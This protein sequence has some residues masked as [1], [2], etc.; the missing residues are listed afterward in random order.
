MAVVCAGFGADDV[1]G[2]L[3]QNAGPEGNRHNWP[4][5]L[6]KTSQHESYTEGRRGVCAAFA[7][8]RCPRRLCDF[9][10]RF[11]ADGFAG[12]GPEACAIAGLHAGGGHAI[13]QDAGV[14]G[15]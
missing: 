13:E 11:I 9:K 8:I 10:C 14:D 12:R 6:G 4:T 1:R 3:S 5:L 2:N 15:R 7:G